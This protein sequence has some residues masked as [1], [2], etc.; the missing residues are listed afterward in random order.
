MLNSNRQTAD[1]IEMGMIRN[2]YVGRTFIQPTQSMRDFSVRVK[3]NPVRKL[4]TRITSYNVCYTKL[5][6]IDWVGWMKVRP[7]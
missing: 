1:V 3:L 6:R 7:T 4:L 2:H 5:L